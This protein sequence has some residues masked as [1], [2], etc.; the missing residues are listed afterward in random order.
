MT[1]DLELLLE[2]A[3]R[4][5]TEDYFG[6]SQEMTLEKNASKSRNHALVPGQARAA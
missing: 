2:A 3:A 6:T 4:G 5:A 1:D